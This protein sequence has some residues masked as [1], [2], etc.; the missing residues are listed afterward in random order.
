MVGLGTHPIRKLKEKPSLS[1]DNRT[2][3][4]NEYWKGIRVKFA[5]QA[6]AGGL[7]FMLLFL[8]CLSYLYGSLYKSHDKYHNLHVLAVDYDSGVIGQALSVAYEQLKG[9]GFPTLYFHL[10]EDF[11][12]QSD[13]YRSV[14]DG[15]YWGAIYSTKGASARLTAAIQDDR[16]ANVYDASNALHWVWN[17]QYYSTF[18]QGAIQAN[19]QQLVGAVRV[20]YTKLNGTGAF[21]YVAQ[22]SPAAVQAFLNPIAATVENVKADPQGSIVFFGT[23]SMA[24]PV[25]QQ[26][27]FLL[28]L[29]GV[30]RQHQIYSKMTIRSS[31]MVRRVCGLL[32]SLGAALV[33]TVYYWAFGDGWDVNANQFV[34]TWMA[35]WLLMN[36]H[37]LFLDAISAI[38]PLPAM[39]FVVL[40]WVF[41]NISTT[42][43]PLEIQPGFYHWGICLPAHNAYSVLVTIWSGG[44][45]NRLYR[46]LPIMFSW[47]IVGNMISIAA[48][49]RACHL[50]FK[51]DDD[52]E[53]KKHDEEY[54]VTSSQEDSNKEKQKP[55]VGDGT[56]DY[57]LTRGKSIKER[58][59]QQR[60]IYGPSVPPPFA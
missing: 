50:A 43:G 28:A 17:Q 32:Y 5:I 1:R 14:R 52:E 19:M 9:P 38:S 18:A 34:L 31:I 53:T 11:P 60:Q 59:L 36:I 54:S 25:L 56:A 4:A 2:S 40:I 13:V 51:F 39:P 8:A 55:S 6:A 57:G 41:L 44:G 30:C 29:N 33:Q 7:A 12:T 15:H 23:V 10:P 58:A 21:P 45:D 26:F 46:A 22:S 37:F 3:F 35:L 42:I 49:L 48:H 47:W 16:T 20:A 27:F 24:M